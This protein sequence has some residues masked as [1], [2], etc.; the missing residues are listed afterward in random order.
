MRGRLCRSRMRSIGG[1]CR[2]LKEGD[3]DVVLRCLFVSVDVYDY[4]E[5]SYTLIRTAMPLPFIYFQT[6]DQ[7]T[8]TL[9]QTRKSRYNRLAI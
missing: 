3:H 1:R 2:G 9:G 8:P 5:I 6:I 7:A 4:F